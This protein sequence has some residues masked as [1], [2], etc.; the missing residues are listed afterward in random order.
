[1]PRFSIN[2]ILPSIY[3]IRS[4]RRKLNCIESTNSSD[5]WIVDSVS[6]TYLQ[7]I[8]SFF[9]CAVINALSYILFLSVSF[10]SFWRYFLESRITALCST[11]I[12][13][14]RSSISDEAEGK[15]YPCSC[16]EGDPLKF[17]ERDVPEIEIFSIM[18]HIYCTLSQFTLILKHSSLPIKSPLNKLCYPYFNRNI[19][20]HS[21]K[22]H[23]FLHTSLAL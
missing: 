22:I 10:T 11:V 23:I 15:I 14:N 16:L 7:W 20:L 12:R 13:N 17:S 19:M 18:S 2:G 3:R 8:C 4:F 6:G 9:L 21:R 5:C 1:M